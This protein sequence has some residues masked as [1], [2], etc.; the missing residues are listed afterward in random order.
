[1][2]RSNSNSILLGNQ[3]HL[4]Q[5]KHSIPVAGLADGSNLYRLLKHSIFITIDPKRDL[6]LCPMSPPSKKKMATS[7]EAYNRIVW[8]T[9]LNPYA[10]AIGYLD[11]TSER[12]HTTA[13]IREKPLTQWQP[14]GDIPW[15]RIR[16]IRCEANMIWHRDEQLDLLSSGPLP[17]AAWLTQPED[18]LT[19]IN[20]PPFTPRP[21]YAYTSQGWH[22]LDRPA[23]TANLT[24]LTI[25]TF[26]VLSDLYEREQIQTEKRLAAI[27]GHL[28]ACNADIIALQEATPALL[29]TLLSQPWIHGYLISEPPDASTLNPYGLLLL[30][31]YPFTLCEHLFADFPG[32][33]PKRV[34]VGTWQID[35]TPFNLAVVHLPSNRTQNAREIRTQHLQ[36]VINYLIS[37]P[38]DCLIA[39]DFNVATEAETHPLTSAGFQDVW[40][41]LHPLNPGHTFDPQRNPLAALMSVR[42]Q[43]ARFDRIF[44]RTENRWQP[45]S[46]ALFACEPIPN[47]DG[48]LYPSDHFGLCAVLAAVQPPDRL[49]TVQPVYRSAVV[50]IPPA[51]LWPAIQAIRQQFDRQIDRWMPH[52]NLLYGFIPETNFAEAAPVIAQMLAD[53]EPF[54]ITLERFEVFTHRASCTA[55]LLPISD[56]PDALQRL[57]SRLQQLFPQCDEQSRKSPAGF[58]PHL[59]VGQFRSPEAARAQLPAWQPVRFRLSEIALIGRGEDT[60]FSVKFRIPLG[61]TAIPLDPELSLSDRQ[62]R[63]TVIAIITQACA[64]CLGDSPVLHVLGSARLGVETA[65]SDLDLL[66]LIPTSQTGRGFLNEVQQ[67]L[68]G[69][70]H[71][72]RLIEAAK[73]PALR[74]C[75]DGIAVDLLWARIP[76]HLGT[77]PPLTPTIRPFLDPVS[78]QAVAGCLEVDAIGKVAGDS[79]DSFRQLLRAVRSWAKTRQIQ[80]NAWGFLGGI[81]WAILAAWTYQRYPSSS[82]APTLESLLAH[83]FQTLAQ[84]DWRQPIALTEAGSRYQPRT[85]RDW[86]PIITSLEPHQNSA[87]NLTRSTA[88]LLRAE[89]TRAAEFAGQQNWQQVFT[90]ADLSLQSELFLIVNAN[91]I[92]ANQ[93]LQGLEGRAIGIILELEQQLATEVRP[94]PGLRQTAAG[95]CAI[96]GLALTPESS[97]RTRLVEISQHLTQPLEGRFCHRQDLISQL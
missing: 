96:F 24:T 65:D 5:D 48:T 1:M 51:E 13:T 89:F 73:V 83:F 69:L 47:T 22:P 29:Q 90:P 21:V 66:C 88:N 23:T 97:D 77:K 76:S 27:T 92:A 64:E 41:T 78:W 72:S 3:H 95:L 33:I 15:H 38:G 4:C 84:H 19:A 53:F 26:N 44:L 37:Q 20:V 11:R 34:L 39:G 85:P 93:L 94:W 2:P 32:T 67:R 74:M 87:R 28:Q 70:C 91:N 68:Q 10:F 52:I 55:W 42:G 86:L 75:L 79:A 7:R 17:A 31:R 6:D 9:R 16:Y 30:S 35:R 58:T 50:A 14:D 46:A 43:A 63:E 12:H 81:S 80:G 61:Q 8:D 49:Q 18:A 25:A 71:H 62:R 36:T 54:E 82:Y 56:P 40:Q 59:S 60:P 45:Q 57:Q